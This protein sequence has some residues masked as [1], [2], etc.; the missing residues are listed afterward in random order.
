[1][2]KQLLPSPES[3]NFSDSHWCLLGIQM[4]EV[5]ASD[6]SMQHQHVLYGETNQ[7]TFRMLISTVLTT[8]EV[9]TDGIGVM[10]AT[11]DMDTALAS[12]G[13]HTVTLTFTEEGSIELTSPV[14]LSAT[15][16]D[17][18]SAVVTSD[19]HPVKTLIVGAER[20]ATF[21]TLSIPCHDGQRYE[22]P[23]MLPLLDGLRSAVGIASVR[24]NG[25]S[26]QGVRITL[27][28][29][30]LRVESAN[31][32]VTARMQYDMPWIVAPQHDEEYILSTDAVRHLIAA[33]SSYAAHAP[34]YLHGHDG[35]LVIQTD[36]VYMEAETA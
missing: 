32:G 13:Q 12:F 17:K 5:A 29:S 18:S 26:M 25:L 11:R 23:D 35:R 33:L 16:D 28:P 8:D 21:P 24:G 14:N 15:A 9:E 10:V 27:S 3:K 34:L 31:P 7:P 19:L 6:G 4:R 2:V 30:C 20:D 22:L 1:M 36:G